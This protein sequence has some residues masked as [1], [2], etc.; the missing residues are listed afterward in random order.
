V[1]Y[2]LRPSP[3]THVVTKDERHFVV[4]EEGDL[5]TGLTHPYKSFVKTATFRHGYTFTWTQDELWIAVQR[6]RVANAK[7]RA[8]VFKDVLPNVP[9]M[10]GCRPVVA[11][12]RAPAGYWWDNPP[13]LAAR[14]VSAA[15]TWVQEAGRTRNTIGA[16]VNDMG[17]V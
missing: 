9:M 15:D 10:L 2:M 16:T 1:N 14:L 3:G 17:R 5:P 11:A 12:I 4:C 13:V 8:L 7:K 6:G